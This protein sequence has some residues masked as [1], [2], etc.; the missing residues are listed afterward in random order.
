MRFAAPV[1]E[2][3]GPAA[4]ILFYIL[5]HSATCRDVGVRSLNSPACN[6]RVPATAPTPANGVSPPRFVQLSIS[7]KPSSR[8][9]AAQSA[10]AC[11]RSNSSS[12]TSSIR[13]SRGSNCSGANVQVLQRHPK[14]IASR[15]AVLGEAA[16]SLRSDL[17]TTG[18]PRISRRHS[19]CEAGASIARRRNCQPAIILPFPFHMT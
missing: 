15:P 14:V 11:K 6:R 16:L 19:P 3:V 12:A 13:C 2:A 8:R 7:D 17:G 1:I 5:P 10:I 4:E 9:R 18:L